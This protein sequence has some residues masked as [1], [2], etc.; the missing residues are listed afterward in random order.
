[1]TIYEILSFNRELL[2]RL[3]EVGIKTSDYRYVDL[4]RDFKKM[5]RQGYKKTYI[6]AIL[7]EK[8]AISERKV[9]ALIRQFSGTAKAVQCDLS[10]E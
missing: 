7:S 9:Y 5:V 3:F 1:M 8:Y 6:V 4:F 10:E 2:Q